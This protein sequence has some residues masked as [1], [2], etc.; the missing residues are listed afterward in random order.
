MKSGIPW[1]VKGIEPE[2]REAAKDA[3]RRSG[4]TLGEWLNTTILEQTEA[5]ASP[6]SRD[7]H[8]L[9]RDRFSRIAEEL[10]MMTAERPQEKPAQP[11]QQPSQA[12]TTLESVIERVE[13][14]ER[15]LTEALTS[16]NERLKVINTQIVRHAEQAADSTGAAES[17]A[18]LEA[19]VRNI[20]GHLDVSQRR[21]QET[22]TTLQDQVRRLG[23]R[24]GEEKSTERLNQLETEIAG[25]YERL[26]GQEQDKALQSVQLQVREI[27]EQLGALK[28]LPDA[29]VDR[30]KQAATGSLRP[31]IKVLES[32]LQSLAA[33]VEASLAHLGGL[34]SDVESLRR[35]VTALKDDVGTLALQAERGS[36][37]QANE[38]EVMLLQSSLERLSARF[39]ELPI[40]GIERRLSEMTRRISDMEIRGRALP[41]ISEVAQKVQELEGRLAEARSPSAAEEV[42][43][44]MFEQMRVFDDRLVGAE[45]KLNSLES[46]ERS[47]SQIFQALEDSRAD[48]QDVAEAAAKRVVSE[49]QRSPM[50]EGIQEPVLAAIEQALNGLRQENQRSEQ[51][52]Q[53]T[54]DALHETLEEIIGRLSEVEGA[55]APAQGRNWERIQAE[56]PP[57]AD[58][59]QNASQPDPQPIAIEPGWRG[60]LQEHLTKAQSE[61]KTDPQLSFEPQR[62]AAEPAGELFSSEDETPP[63][64]P[65][66]ERPDTVSGQE[67]DFI[68]AARRAAQAAAQGAR[69]SLGRVPQTKGKAERGTT[70][71]GLRL[72]PLSLFQRPAPVK[73]R[74]PKGVGDEVA[75]AAD[76]AKVTPEG[77][78]RRLLLAALLLLAAVSA[79]AV[80]SGYKATLTPDPAP[81]SKTQSDSHSGAPQSRSAFQANATFEAPAA[82]AEEIDSPSVRLAALE[83]QAE[84]EFIIAGRYIEGSNVP[85]NPVE[86][87]K[88]YHKAAEQGLAPAQYRL[89]TLYERGIGVEQSVGAAVHWYARAADQGN[90]KAMHNLGVLLAQG[91]E[92]DYATVVRWF[93]AAAT[94]GIKDSQYN[95]AMLY[96]RGLGVKK[97][98]AEAM[99]WYLAAAQQGDEEALKKAETLGSTLAPALAQATRERFEAW[100]P[101][102]AQADANVVSLAMARG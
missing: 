100:K 97:D 24:S 59:L 47:V 1:S 48:V 3:A 52:T 101:E 65:V 13:N 91:P 75:M 51:Q 20:V 84:A 87:A 2:V 54:F 19:A 82:L 63:A 93:T 16:V 69:H 38:R 9:V 10:A 80:R 42:F 17:Y 25:L 22:I 86:A 94:H 8:P 53:E 92:A 72:F 12:D 79:Y 70:N 78:K 50:S 39:E 5:R 33:N 4:L 66:Q 27:Y 14:H 62:E 90:V 35:E 67:D 31:E 64:K 49:L 55:Q 89:S 23:D 71:R 73:P 43:D 45:A 56:A 40:V 41:H 32:T 6:K 68:A 44:Q 85:Q 96:E 29:L 81:Q 102:K 58:T 26:E 61:L 36:S 95:V 76:S 28:S 46:I 74:H 77:N 98:Q 37:G 21:T 83:G 30:A 60:N 11:F 18:S 57:Q 99:F 34:N 88:W 7:M 15:Y